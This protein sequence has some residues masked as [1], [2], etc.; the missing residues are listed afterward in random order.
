MD[1]NLRGEMSTDLCLE[2]AD[3]GVRVMLVSG[4]DSASL[5]DALASLP[6]VQKPVGA[7]ALVDRLKEVVRPPLRLEAVADSSRTGR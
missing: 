6:S 5:P 3:R 2:L 7:A 4:Y 1:I